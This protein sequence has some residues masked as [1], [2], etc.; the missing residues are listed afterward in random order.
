MHRPPAN[1][2]GGCDKWAGPRTHFY[3]F[4]APIG[5]SVAV[6]SFNIARVPTLTVKLSVGDDGD[7]EPLRF[8]SHFRNKFV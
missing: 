8:L 3:H 7:V 6:S 2:R 5:K 1:H 4:V